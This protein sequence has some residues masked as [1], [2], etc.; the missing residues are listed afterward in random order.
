MPCVR[1]QGERMP[2]FSLFGLI[3]TFT[4]SGQYSLMSRYRRHIVGYD[5]DAEGALQLFQDTDTTDTPSYAQM[6][7][8]KYSETDYVNEYLQAKNI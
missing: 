8:I 7:I 3:H 6:Y 2:A 5:Q 1:N 4:I